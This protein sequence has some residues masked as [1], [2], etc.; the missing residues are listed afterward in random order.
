MLRS[1]EPVLR[2]RERV[3]QPQGPVLQ[4]QG[5]VLQ[6]WGWTRSRPG[7]SLGGGTNRGGIGPASRRGRVCTDSRVTREEAARAYPQW[8]GPADGQL[9]RR[10]SSHV[11][12]LTFGPSSG[13]WLAK[14]FLPR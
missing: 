11:T 6:L 4:F 9:L 14:P 13:A 5:P 7:S 8:V 12:F 3:L 2:F 1:P 10:Y